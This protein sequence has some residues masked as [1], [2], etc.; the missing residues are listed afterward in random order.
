MLRTLALAC[1]AAVSAALLIAPP[2]GA[3]PA[4]VAAAPSVAPAPRANVFPERYSVKAAGDLVITGNTLLTCSTSVSGCSAALN[5]TGT[6]NLN[7]NDYTM[8][9][10]DIDTDAATPNSSSADLRIPDRAP[11]LLAGL[12]WGAGAS[13]D[14]AKGYAPANADRVKLRVPGDASYRTVVAQRYSP[15]ST[16]GSNKTYTAFTDVTSIVRAV[17]RGTYTVADVKADLGTNH[18]AGW[19]LVVVYGDP[20]EPVR[21]ISVY[22]GVADV[23]SSRPATIDVSGFLTPPT[24]PVRTALGMVA[25]EGDLGLTG[26]KFTLNGKALSDSVRSGTNFWNSTIT[27]RTGHFTA[28]SPDYRNQL[29]FDAG[30]VDATGRIPNNATKATFEAA[31]EGDR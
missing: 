10:V 6:K 17:G 31:S 13:G 22:D 21:A 4:V 26:D 8:I 28:K 30:L 12:Y 20:T 23:S 11:V 7:N 25:Y 14:Q 27:T 18:F 5:T 19:S 2:A 3:A 15:I 24:G 1:S 29:G 16:K 9:M